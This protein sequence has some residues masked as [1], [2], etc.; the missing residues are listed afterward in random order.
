[1][2][3]VVSVDFETHYGKGYSIK[4]MIAEQ[5]VRHSRFDPYML[6]VCDGSES[7]AG[8]PKNFNWD[9]LARKTLVSH[10]RYF[11]NSVY[12]EMVRR[13]WVPQITPAAWHCTSNLTSYI[14]NR[15]ALDQAVEYL[16]KIKL[17]KSARADAEDKNWPADFSFAEQATM[18]EY[19]RGDAVWCWRLWNDF[20]SRWPEHEQRLSNLTIEQGMRGVQV[21]RAML[22]G[23]ILATHEMKLA[24]EKL[25]PWLK[26]TW[27]DE[28]A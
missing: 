15:R 9:A 21:D 12:N 17:S 5:Y 11:D 20:S 1:M 27:D 23:Y 25:L 26:D 22:D 4:T 7:W 10:N 2:S 3:N 28:G 16:Y 24:T 18:L 14:C 19:A 6:T 8:S 13:N